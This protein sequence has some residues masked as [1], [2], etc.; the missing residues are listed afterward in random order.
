MTGQPEVFNRAEAAEFA[1]VSAAT[2]DRWLADGLVHLRTGGK[3]GGPGPSG[4]IVLREHLIGYI[5]E[6]ARAVAREEPK[7]RARRKPRRL[8]DETPRP[9]GSPWVSM[10]K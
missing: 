5:R 8:A 4:V 2:I 9:D 10:P 6:R 1:R 3:V 7:A